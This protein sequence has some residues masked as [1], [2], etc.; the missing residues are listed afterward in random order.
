M[1][2]KSPFFSK[3]ILACDS[4]TGFRLTMSCKFDVLRPKTWDVYGIQTP[5]TWCLFL[6]PICLVWT[7]GRFSHS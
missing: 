2:K 4:N 6:R 3:T 1:H 5:H 7:A